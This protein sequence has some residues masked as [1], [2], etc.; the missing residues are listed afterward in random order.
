MEGKVAQSCPTLS[1][2][3]DYTVR[4]ILQARILERVAFPFSRGSF[5]LWDQTQVSHIAGVGGGGS[6]PVKPQGKPKNTGVGSLS[7]LQQKREGGIF[8]PAS[9]CISRQQQVS[10]W[11]LFPLNWLPASSRSSSL[12]DMTAQNP[13]API[14]GW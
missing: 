13:C 11:L 12:R 4:G 1:D 6:L 9:G 7:L 8:S 5:Q 2:I 10:L 14:T 3:M